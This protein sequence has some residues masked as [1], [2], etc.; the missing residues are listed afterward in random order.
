MTGSEACVRT[1]E[2]LGVQV[3][4][5]LCGDTTLPLYEA[6]HDIDHGMRHVLTRDERSHR[7]SRTPTH[8]SAG[9]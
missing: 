4:F 8:G 5:G 1:L 2:R 6:L 3:I 9:A 7:S